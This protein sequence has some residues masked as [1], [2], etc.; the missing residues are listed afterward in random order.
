MRYAVIPLLVSAV[1]HVL[2]FGLTGLASGSLFLLFPAGLYCL[3]SISLLRDITWIAWVTL[4][5]MI[6]GA[7]GSMIEFT[8]PL[9]APWPVLIG[10]IVADLM[11]AGL[12]IMGLW[13][14]HVGQGAR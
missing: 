4:V 3:L 14:A 2:G 11:T 8:G 5:C 9:M 1:L 12:L 7:L 6:G 10:I 13:H